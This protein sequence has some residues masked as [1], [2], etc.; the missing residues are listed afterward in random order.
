[1]NNK[2]AKLW[3]EGLP[4]PFRSQAIDNYYNVPRPHTDHESLEAALAGSFDSWSAPEGPR[5]W[6]AIRSMAAAG[7]FD[8]FVPVFVGEIRAKERLTTG[9][10]NTTLA[11]FAFGKFIQVGCTAFSRKEIEVFV[12]RAKVAGETWE[13]STFVFK[14]QEIVDFIEENKEILFGRVAASAVAV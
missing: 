9:N 11:I 4:E 1:M 13:H 2:S 3:L 10:D 14:T 12:R 8:D 5:Y 6:G 7:V